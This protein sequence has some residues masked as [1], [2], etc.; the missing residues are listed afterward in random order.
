MAVGKQ[1]YNY[2]EVPEFRFWASGDFLIIHSTALNKEIR[3]SL[4]DLGIHFQNRDAGTTNNVFEIQ[5]Q[6]QNQDTDGKTILVFR[7]I[8]GGGTDIAIGNLWDAIAGTTALKLCLDYTGTVADVW[9]EIG[10]GGSFETITGSPRDNAALDEELTNL[11]DSLTIGD[12]TSASGNFTTGDT[13]TLAFRKIRSFIDGINSTIRNL[14]FSDLNYQD[15]TGTIADNL[16]TWI[17]KLQGQIS[18]S[19]NSISTLITNISANT[20]AIGTLASLNTTAKNNLVAAINELKGLFPISAITDK[21][22]VDLSPAYPTSQEII[23]Y[24]TVTALTAFTTNK[25]TSTAIPFSDIGYQWKT[26]GGSWSTAALIGTNG[27][28]LSNT[29]VAQNTVS[30]SKTMLRLVIANTSNN[31]LTSATVASTYAS[32]VNLRIT[33]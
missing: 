27:V 32:A 21:I 30:T 6:S 9:N 8:Q 15:V 7:G 10:G 16:E 22:Q 2:L 19:K 3:I 13:L 1:E 14:T 20:S 17:G 33:A 29:L 24:G 28:T 12:I 4:A 25:E 31:G 26:E 23:V 11:Q 5:Y 18:A